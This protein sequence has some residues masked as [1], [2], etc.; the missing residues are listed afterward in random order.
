ME[1]YTNF[2]LTGEKSLIDG[3][4]DK[5]DSSYAIGSSGLSDQQYDDLIDLYTTRFGPRTVIGAP[6]TEEDVPLPIAMM[7][8]DKVFKHEP[9][10]LDNWISK[11][12]GPY[13]AMDKINGNS[14]LYVIQG[15]KTSL[16]KRGDGIKGPDISRI[17]PYLNL[18]VLPFDIHIKGEMVIDKKDFEPFKG[19]G[20]D[21]YKTNLSMVS[22]LIN[23]RNSNPDPERLKLIKFIAFD[24]SFPNNPEI[25]LTISQ[26]LENLVKY[27]FRVPFYMKT[28]GLTFE[29]LG[30]LYERQKT[31][32]TYDVDGIVIVADK[33]VTYPERLIRENPKYSI[34]YKE[35]GDVYETTVTHVVWEASKHGVLTPV[36]HVVDTPVGDTG[37]TIRH[38]TGHNARFLVDNGIGVG[39]KIQVVMNTIPKIIGTIER[40][41]PDL[42]NSDKYPPGSW[43]WND[44]G[45]EIVLKN[46]DIDEVKIARLYEF[47][48]KDKINAKGWGEK[49]VEA[50]YNAGFDTLKKL[51][52]TDKGGFMAVPIE[53]V[54][55]RGIDNLVES[56][57]VSLKQA[58]L[59]TI[60]AGSGCF[61]HGIGTRMIKKV[62]DSYPNIL[63]HEV[64]LEQIVDLEG[65]ADK[66]AQ[67][68][69]EGLPKFRQL[70]IEIPILN[71]VARTKNVEPV[72]VVQAPLP[73]GAESISGKAVVFTGFRD[74]EMEEIIRSRGGEVKTGV[75]KKVNY[76]VLG[77]PKGEGSSKEK[78]AINYSIPILS[79][80][81]F[82]SKFGL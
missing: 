19:N 2:I 23:W 71:K 21:Q 45:A 1:Q 43:E 82:K 6:A 60:M 16:Y 69:I 47:F 28:P 61:D 66:K 12:L 36:V 74:K 68:F 46:K 8:L 56:R 78:K 38:P 81:E 51:L 27:G 65:F 7:S 73:I 20:D 18:P 49:K 75:T 24:M 77:G 13:V 67:K 31:H 25:E 58:G 14:G 50:F 44:T 52:E 72:K 53:G 40:V 4:L 5:V 17:I 34:A 79:V 37:Y 33:K 42:P 70:L 22:G 39:A 64:T 35:Q 76:L 80:D 63:D 48:K 10:K 54:G 41:T 55:E 30:Q 9:K 62:L 15:G 57:D 11:N 29:W 32:Q 3:W 59:A 26:T